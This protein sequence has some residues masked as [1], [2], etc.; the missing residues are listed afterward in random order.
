MVIQITCSGWQPRG[1][2]VRDRL[3]RRSIKL[4]KESRILS[5]RWHNLR[6]CSNRSTTWVAKWK[7]LW[8]KI[9]TS[10]NTSRR[11]SSRQMRMVWSMSCLI[12]KKERLSK[13]A[14]QW[15]KPSLTK[16]TKCI[17]KR[18]IWFL[19]TTAP[20]WCSEDRGLR[21]QPKPVQ[22]RWRLWIRVKST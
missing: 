14:I 19:P 3:R 9:W 18:L 2:E 1:E 20:A 15:M 6:A 4:S 22:R 7:R 21:L 13:Q 11:V 12:Q 8:L 5:I 16:I 17:N 10:G